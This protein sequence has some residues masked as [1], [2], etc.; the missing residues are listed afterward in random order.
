MVY[1][2]NKGI[3]ND[4][5]TLDR[6]YDGTDWPLIRYTEI[7]LMWAEAL[8]AT[9]QVADAVN[10]LNEV[11][12]RGGMPA[13]TSMDPAD[14]LKEIRYETRVELCLE[15][16]DFFYEIRWNTF[17]Q[18]KFNNKNFWDPRTC[19]NQGGWKTGYYYVEHMWPLSAPLDEIVM[20]ANLKRRPWCWTY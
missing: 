7:Q 15:G 10:L 2:W 20:N 17:K 19:W 8:L 16:K 5:S 11:R 4:G 3:V 12:T 13:V 14:V 9:G 1:T 18:K 6:W